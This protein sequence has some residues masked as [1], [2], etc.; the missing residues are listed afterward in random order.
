MTKK[1]E[2]LKRASKPKDKGNLQL[3]AWLSNKKGPIETAAYMEAKRRT[4]NAWKSSDFQTA[5]H[6]AVTLKTLE[7]LAK[8]LESK[9]LLTRSDR[10]TL[11]RFVR[12]REVPKVGRPRGPLSGNVAQRNAVYWVRLGQQK[13]LKENGRQRV[14]TS[15]T[16]V[17]IADAINLASKAFPLLPKPRADDVRA[18]VN[19]ASRK[20]IE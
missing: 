11:A 6:Y 7:P 9:A 3:Q 5:M 15:V 20:I 17:L 4:R 12:S 2:P 18:L 16:V 14:P 10:L 13:W 1:G 8:F 19:K